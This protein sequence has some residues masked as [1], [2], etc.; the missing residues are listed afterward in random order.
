MVSQPQEARIRLRLSPACYERMCRQ[1]S[2]RQ[3]HVQ[4]Y[5]RLVVEGHEEDFTAF[6]AY[7]ASRHATMAAF[8]MMV[9]LQVTANKNFNA[10]VLKDIGKHVHAVVGDGPGKPTLSGE[11]PNV[12]PDFFVEGL[13]AFY[14]RFVVDRFPDMRAKV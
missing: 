1:A 10:D 13:M 9:Y 11:T 8:V 12:D 14:G 4:D 5:I 7:N 3:L 6:H 2:S